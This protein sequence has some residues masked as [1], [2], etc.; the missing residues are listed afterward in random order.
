M[1]LP[2]FERDPGA[3]DELERILRARY[4]TLHAFIDDGR[5]FVRGTLEVVDGDRYSLS[6]AL[7]P[8]YPHSIPVVWETAG[9]IPREV[10]RHVY[11]DHSLCLGTPLSLWID[12]DGDFAIERVLDIPVRNF[13]V[14]NS[15]VEEGQPWPYGDRSH[16]AAG[17][18]EHLRELIGSSDTFVVAQFLI[19]ILQCKIKGH[20][21]CPCGSGQIIRKCHREAVEKMRRVPPYVVDHALDLIMK[22]LKHRLAA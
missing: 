9:R 11:P 6:I 1:S 21:P 4:P 5:C 18:V 22:D 19:N 17:I 3:L 14:G 2:W 12:L 16:G 7:P 8:N 13:L 10:D 15:L 20:W